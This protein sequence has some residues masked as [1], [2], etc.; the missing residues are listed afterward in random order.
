PSATSLSGTT[1]A[2][3]IAAA[4]TTTRSAAY[5]TARPC[6][7][8]RTRSSRKGL[9]RPRPFDR[10]RMRQTSSC[11]RPVFILTALLLGAGIMLRGFPSAAERARLV[12]PPAL[13]ERANPQTTSEVAVLAGGCFW[14]VQG[15]FQH[16]D[17]VTSAVSGYAGGS[18]NA[19]HYEMV[20]T[21]TTG[22]A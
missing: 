18:A 9:S 8:T 20:G 13:D 19:A 16:V 7:I 11:C 15:V 17:G 6:R 21:N 2:Q 14:G 10:P 5:C 12:P 4:P 22:H 3:C 1:V